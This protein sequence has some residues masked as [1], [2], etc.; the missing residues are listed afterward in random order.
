MNPFNALEKLDKTAT[1]AIAHTSNGREMAFSERYIV[2]GGSEV[3]GGRF[4]MGTLTSHSIWLLV[5]KIQVKS[6]NL[7]KAV[8]HKGFA[9][10]FDLNKGESVQVKRL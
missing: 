9:L 1:P 6:M 10:H 8:E 4:C 5:F 3:L 2:Q 7:M